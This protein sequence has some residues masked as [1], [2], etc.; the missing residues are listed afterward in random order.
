MSVLNDPTDEGEY[1]DTSIEDRHPLGFAVLYLMLLMLG[2][3][4][5]VLLV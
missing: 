3:I 5:L 1:E 2:A 4:A